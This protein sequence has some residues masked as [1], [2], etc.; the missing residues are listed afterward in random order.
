MSPKQSW[1]NFSRWAPEGNAVSSQPR[2][3]YKAKSIRQTLH[4]VRSP[5]KIVCNGSM[6]RTVIRYLKAN[7]TA[8]VTVDI[9]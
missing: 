9:L 1:Q 4:G 2:L 5:L 3:G 6:F 8:C 7:T